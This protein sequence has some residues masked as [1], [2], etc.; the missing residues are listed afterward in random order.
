MRR[1]KKLAGCSITNRNSLDEI[2]LLDKAF[3]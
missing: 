2:K 1:H 3:N